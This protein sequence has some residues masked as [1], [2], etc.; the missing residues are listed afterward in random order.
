[1]AFLRVQFCL[2]FFDTTDRRAVGYLVVLAQLSMTN[3]LYM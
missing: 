3:H 2:V 1:M